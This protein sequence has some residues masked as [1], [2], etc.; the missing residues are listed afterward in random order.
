MMVERKYTPPHHAG[1]INAGIFHSEPPS[2][3]H[4]NPIEGTVDLITSNPAHTNGISHGLFP[5]QQVAAVAPKS[6]KK[7]DK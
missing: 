5:R 4:E 2:T 6:P 7:I 3:A 1:C